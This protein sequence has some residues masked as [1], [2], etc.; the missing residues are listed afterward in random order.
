MSSRGEGWPSSNCKGWHRMVPV[1]LTASRHA[2]FAGTV[3]FRDSPSSEDEIL[4]EQG[5]R[6]EPLQPVGREIEARL[7]PENLLRERAPDSRALHEAVAGEP[8]GRVDAVGDQ[9]ED[10]VSVGRHVIQTG[11]RAVDPGARGGR[12]AMDETSEPVAVER[13]VDDFVEA[14]ARLGIA[15][16]QHE[17]VAPA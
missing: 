10:W 1:P 8:A 9:A 6:L 3:P 2:A 16:R 17:P 14:P 13:L 11:P 15:H 7:E 5:I 4:L 12:V